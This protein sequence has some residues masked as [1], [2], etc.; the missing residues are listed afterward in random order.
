[1]V[2]APANPEPHVCSFA[3]VSVWLRLVWRN[4]GVPRRYWGKLAQVLAVSAAVAPLRLAE[5]L[6][7]SH[8]AKNVAITAPPVFILGL[9]RTGTTHLHN[10]LAQDPNLGY[11]DTYQSAVPTFSLVGG[12]WLRRLMARQVGERSRPMDNVRLALDTPQEEEIALANASRLASW[13]HLMTFPKQS[14]ELLTKYALM[15]WGGE[16]ALSER[17]AMRWHHEY[18]RIVLKA[19]LCAGGRR[20]VLKSP[21][22]LGR[23]DHLLRLFPHA[24]F[25]HIVRN[26]Y[27]VFESLMRTLRIVMPA[28]QMDDYDPEQH[29]EQ[30]ADA[31]RRFCEKYEQDRPLVPPGNLAE[32]RFEDLERDPLGELER[33]YAELSLPGWEQAEPAIRAYVGTLA[34]YRKNTYRFEQDVIDRVQE[35]WRFAVDGW[36]Y[37][38]PA[39]STP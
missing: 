3:P 4:G 22:N 15:G 39:A 5:A 35:R 34:Q 38:P 28:Y 12:A 13:M 36:G 26:P 21:A 16:N 10:L 1:M 31:C 20:L 24:K 37:E 23:V 25:I 33:L 30:M 19:T 29:M 32:V 17:E 11:L 6:R 14:D 7:Y 27:V 9:A 8:V 18:L 2:D